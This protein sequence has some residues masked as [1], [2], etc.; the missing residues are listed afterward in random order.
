M[1]F[2]QDRRFA[3]ACGCLTCKGALIA[4]KDSANGYKHHRLAALAALSLDIPKKKKRYYLEMARFGAICA[5]SNF[6][7]FKTRL[8][9]N[10][11]NPD[12]KHNIDFVEWSGGHS[13]KL[14]V[15]VNALRS[16]KTGSTT[17]SFDH[18]GSIAFQE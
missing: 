8:A 10:N 18:G 7:F 17:V 4:I 11:R 2:I 1:S 13:A 5:R 16:K 9:E 14:M 12:R 15:T 3:E 6:I